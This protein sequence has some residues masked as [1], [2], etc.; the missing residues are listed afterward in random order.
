MM[1]LREYSDPKHQ[2]K[3]Q[4]GKYAIIG[5]SQPGATEET[6]DTKVLQNK[7]L[8][9]I[10]NILKSGN[11]D[12]VVLAT[13]RHPECPDAEK[14]AFTGEETA[15]LS[16]QNA[17]PTAP[18]LLAT[19]KLL[20]NSEYMDR[21]ILFD[22]DRARSRE[23]LFENATLRVPKTAKVVSKVWMGVA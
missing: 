2:K 23:D 15:G 17:Y 9:R 21:I 22:D 1:N 5:T 6:L 20:Q 13:P 8:C 7:I 16:E 11:A 18:T 10:R 12:F 14:T 3:I 19:F 4:K